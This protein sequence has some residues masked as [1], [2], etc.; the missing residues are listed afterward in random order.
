MSNLQAKADSQRIWRT[1]K[2][3]FKF[4]TSK[5]RSFPPSWCPGYTAAGA[6]PLIR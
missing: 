4:K 5:D 2:A 3:V 1:W 6:T